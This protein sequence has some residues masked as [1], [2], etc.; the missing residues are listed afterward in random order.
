MEQKVFSSFEIQ[1]ILN[2]V[3][4]QYNIRKAILF[5]SY[6]KGTAS[7]R[8]DVD[9]FVDSGLKG[10][11]FYGFLE[12]VVTALNKRVDML[13]SSQ[14]KIGSEVDLEIKESGMVIYEQ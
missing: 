1:Q 10:L 5:G 7:E 14:V 3:F 2:P 4:S 8:S 13:D 6:A 11:S 12:D 9:L